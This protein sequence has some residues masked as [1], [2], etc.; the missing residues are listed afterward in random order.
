ML[1]ELKLDDQYEVKWNSVIDVVLY[2]TSK[3]S[4]F[5]RYITWGKGTYLKR[6]YEEADWDDGGRSISHL[7]LVVHGVGQKG[8]ESLI[9]RNTEQ[10]V[11]YMD[12]SSLKSL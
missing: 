10:Y 11:F 4:R 7:V 3:T 12:I 5:L 6:G 8:Y 9:A 1:T 2:N